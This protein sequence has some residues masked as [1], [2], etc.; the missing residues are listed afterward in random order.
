MLARKSI[1]K[2]KFYV[3]KTTKILKIDNDKWSQKLQKKTTSFAPKKSSLKCARNFSTLNEFL[4]I[5]LKNYFDLKVV[6]HRDFM[7]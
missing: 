7:V 1:L 3:T 4:N 2:K 5:C 6:P